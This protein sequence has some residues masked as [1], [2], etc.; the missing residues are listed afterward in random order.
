MGLV[1]TGARPLQNAGFPENET[2]LGRVGEWET[3]R[4][5]D[6]E[7]GKIFP[8]SLEPQHSSVESVKLTPRAPFSIS[9]LWASSPAQPTIKCTCCGTGILPVLEN[10]AL[11]VS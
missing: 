7:N 9:F 8:L 11:G 5:G 1:G 10:G 2:A 6:W 3:R 4:L